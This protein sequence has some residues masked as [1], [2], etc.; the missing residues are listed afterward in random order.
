MGYID[1]YTVY[2]KLLVLNK[3]ID[4]KLTKNKIQFKI[5]KTFYLRP[6]PHLLKLLIRHL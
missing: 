5:S 4:R 6:H 2:K 1:T 3:N